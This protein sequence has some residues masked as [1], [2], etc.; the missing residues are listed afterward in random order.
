LNEIKSKHHEPT[1]KIVTLLQGRVET[2]Q[3]MVDTGEVMRDKAT[4]DNRREVTVP[5]AKACLVDEM[6]NLAQV[7]HEQGAHIPPC[8]V[9]RCSL[10]PSDEFFA[11]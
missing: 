2:A 4:E 7:Q 3:A 1:D 11:C 8:H 9:N 6:A 5:E 10:I